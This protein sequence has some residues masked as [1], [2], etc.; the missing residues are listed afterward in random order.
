MDLTTLSAI[1]GILGTLAPGGFVLLFLWVILR[2]ESR[3]TLIH[4][5][6]QL[7]H[8]SQEVA[9]P[10]IKAF[11]NEQNSLMSFRF[12]AGVPVSNLEQ[13]RQLIRWTKLRKVEMFALRM[14]GRYFDPDKRQV[15]VDDLPSKLTQRIWLASF[16][17]LL[18]VIFASASLAFMNSALVKVRVTNRWALLSGDEAKPAW[19]LTSEILHKTNCSINAADTINRSNFTEQEAGVLCGLLKNDET[20]NYT[21][22]LVRKQRQS[23]T[24]LFFISILA[25]VMFLS[26]LATGF[27]AKQ[28][29]DKNLDPSIPND[30]DRPRSDSYL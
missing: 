8:G 7:V 12:I 22:E 24:F 20:A 30:S 1:S 5:L 23:L 11:I 3:H 2:T 28:L 27:A 9:D 15:R 10:E 26:K 16:L 29:R 4:R 19:P 17:L 14:A 21:R 18:A 25:A 13:A 6:W